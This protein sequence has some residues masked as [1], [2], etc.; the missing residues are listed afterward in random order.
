MK[1]QKKL[2]TKKQQRYI[3]DKSKDAK[4]EQVQ[5]LVGSELLC[6]GLSKVLRT[7]V[8]LTWITL[9]FPSGIGQLGK[10]QFGMQHNQVYY[11]FLTSIWSS[12]K[13]NVLRHDVSCNFQVS[14]Q[15]TSSQ[16]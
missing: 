9:Q 4:G 11:L 16:Q 3:Y 13:K 8:G 1:M 5:C 15:E 14:A 2:K 10:C 7:S 12:H 6:S